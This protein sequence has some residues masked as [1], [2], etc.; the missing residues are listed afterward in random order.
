MTLHLS[1]GRENELKRLICKIFS[2]FCGIAANCHVYFSAFYF[3]YILSIYEKSINILYI[4]TCVC[5]SCTCLILLLFFKISVFNIWMPPHQCSSTVSSHS[6]ASH[7]LTTEVMAQFWEAFTLSFSYIATSVCV[8]QEI[9]YVCKVL[10]LQNIFPSGGKWLLL[11]V[12]FVL[13]VFMQL[14]NCIVLCQAMICQ[15]SKSNFVFFISF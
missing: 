6:M 8:D 15:L 10:R 14:N 5:V 2:S 11:H 1:T 12:L 7:S 13:R 9:I 4:Y 3:I